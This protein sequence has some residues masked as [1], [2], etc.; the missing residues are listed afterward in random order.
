MEANDRSRAG[1]KSAKLE[2]FVAALTTQP[3]I[4]LAAKSIGISEITAY[5]WLR[6]PI[7]SERR[8]EAARESSQLAMTRL[9][10]VMCRA[11]NR[12]GNLVD[13]AEAENTQVAACKAVLDFSLKVAELEDL[14]QQINEIQNI[15]KSES[16]RWT[17][18]SSSQYHPTSP[19][20]RA[21]EG[22]T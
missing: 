16:R 3:T 4:E 11:V 10:E 14:Q 7:V 2:Q 18:G 8:R 1:K 15:L 21:D 12:L 6:D 5:R 13:H 22:L 19:P 9:R 17:N 20:D